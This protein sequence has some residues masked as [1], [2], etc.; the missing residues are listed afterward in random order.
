MSTSNPVHT[1]LVRAGARAWGIATGLVLGFGLFAATLVL[2]IKGGPEKGAHLGRLSQVFPG[3]DV[4]VGGA[5]LGLLYAFV[6]GYALGRLLSPRAA[7]SVT[8]LAAE[9][10][11]HVRLNGNAWGLTIGGVL[12]VVV[13]ATTIALAV[14]GGE[15]PGDLIEHLA[16][17]FPGY[18]VTIQGGFIGAAWSF[19]LGWLLGRLIGVVYNVTVARAEEKMARA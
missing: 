10:D 12:G 7:V 2:V 15:H 5:F 17:Y 16:I 18:T 4:T 9:R 13:L 1:T 6:V 19:A 11:K 8:R 14:R 3:Y